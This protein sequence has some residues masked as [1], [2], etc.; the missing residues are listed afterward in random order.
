MTAR[1]TSTQLT[2]IHGAHDTF[3]KARITALAKTQILA[4]TEIIFKNIFALNIKIHSEKKDRKNSKIYTE[5]L[6]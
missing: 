1:A 6:A 5:T 4:T 2:A 3:A